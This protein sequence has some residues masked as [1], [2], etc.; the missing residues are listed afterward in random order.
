MSAF[1]CGSA[2]PSGSICMQVDDAAAGARG[3]V[4]ALVLEQLSAGV[5][6]AA[7][8]KMATRGNLL[9]RYWDERID[10][11]GVPATVASGRK[12]QPVLRVVRRCHRRAPERR[13][14]RPFRSRRP[15]PPRRRPGPG[16]EARARGRAG[17]DG[18]RE[19]EQFALQAVGY[20]HPG[21]RTRPEG[22]RDRGR[23]RTQPARR[24]PTW[25]RVPGP[26][27]AHARSRDP[28][29]RPVLVPILS[30]SQSVSR[31]LLEFSLVWPPAGAL[32]PHHEDPRGRLRQIAASGASAH[33]WG[34]E[35]N[36]ASSSYHGT[37]VPA[38]HTQSQSG[39]PA[40]A[41]AIR[42]RRGWRASWP[43]PAGAHVVNHCG[44]AREMIA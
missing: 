25:P 21:P 34:D 6:P 44:L 20:A 37:G 16:Q 33:I 32:S 19:R 28:G 31:Q 11:L 24:L 12:V 15:S 38:L 43:E 14:R 7:F 10:D 8:A 1:I 9:E 42:S 5:S 29:C 13:A 36:R 35:W 39:C 26:A 2:R 41:G 30:R 22:H 3:P 40:A 27:R 17:Q 23:S 18:P 4:V